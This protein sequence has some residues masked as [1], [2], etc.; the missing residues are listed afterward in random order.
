MSIATSNS[1]SDD[2][3]KARLATLSTIEKQQLMESI[4]ADLAQSPATSKSPPWHQEIVARRLQM[5]EAG[6]AEVE[7]WEDVKR[8]L[9]EL[10]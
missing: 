8:E 5:M 2:P 10:N 6:T 4:W 7:D 9:D 1:G 3:W